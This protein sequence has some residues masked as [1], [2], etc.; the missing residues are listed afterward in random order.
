MT[1]RKKIIVKQV[2]IEEV[3]KVNKT[4]KEFEPYKKEYFEKN[5]LKLVIVAYVGGQPAGYIVGYDKFND[6]SFYCWMAGVNPKFRR[7]GVMKALMSYQEKWAKK[8]GYNKIRIKTRNS[9]REMLS[10]LIK[11]GFYIVGL[12]EYPDVKDNKILFERSI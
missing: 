3:V 9:R 5:V 8:N 12:T 6:G 4:I 1:S 11:Y 2:P 10:Y 7:M